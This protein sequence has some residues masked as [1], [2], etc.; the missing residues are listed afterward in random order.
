MS[1]Q[2]FINVDESIETC[3]EMSV[4]DTCIASSIQETQQEEESVEDE[5]IS[6]PHVSNKAAKQAVDQVCTFLLQ[7]SESGATN[8]A[9]QLALSLE[10]CI[11]E[12][13]SQAKKQ[14]TIDS[15]FQ[16]CQFF[17]CH[18]SRK[19]FIHHQSNQIHVVHLSNQAVH[20]WTK[21]RPFKDSFL[22]G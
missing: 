20:L 11:Q 13:T 4:V 5:D 10:N 17:N 19:H 2:D 15:F 3:E 7:Q 9:L 16:H 18:L 6:V 8:K 1:V 12:I 22:M 14:I 21:Q